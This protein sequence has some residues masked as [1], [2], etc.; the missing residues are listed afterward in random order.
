VSNSVKDRSGHGMLP[1]AERRALGKAAAAKR[2][3][4]R[5]RKQLLTKIGKVAAPFGLVLLVVGAVWIFTGNDAPPATPSASATPSAE[6]EVE[7]TT[8]PASVLPPGADPALATKPVVGSSTEVP[9]ELGVTTLITGTGAPTANGQSITVNYVGATLATG[10]EFDSSWKR[11]DTFTFTLG[12][13]GVIQGWDQGLVGIP[14]GS[15][16]QLDI[17]MALAYPNGDGPAGDLR[18]VVDVL[19]AV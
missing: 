1:K 12:E 14:V 15:R 8:A 17:P 7:N 4:Q 19:K 2:A 5:R 18:F 13:G 3:A 10:V 6:V 11:N 9:T 16:V